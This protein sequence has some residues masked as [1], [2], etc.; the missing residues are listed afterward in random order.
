[1]EKF[2]KVE[3]EQY[4]CE[5]EN[6]KF[7]IVIDE[8]SDSTFYEYEIEENKKIA[9]CCSDTYSPNI[10]K[11][12]DYFFIYYVGNCYI[13]SAKTYELIKLLDNLVYVYDIITFNEY[14]CII[15]EIDV[16]FLS[17]ELNIDKQIKFSDVIINYTIDN[18]KLTID[19]D[20]GETI[21]I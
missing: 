2:I 12:N 9:I 6:N 11:I 7:V 10:K 20:N 3:K 16:I 15:S 17:D 21:T 18:N 13:Y 14:F 5:K 1:M 4:I 8:T 19:L